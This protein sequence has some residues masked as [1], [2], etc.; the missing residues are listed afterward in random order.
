MA[1]TASSPAEITELLRQWNDGRPG[2]LDQLMPVVIEPLRQLARSHLR[3]EAARHSL[4][5]TALVNEVYLRLVERQQV[6]WQ[7]RSQFFGCTAQLM[8]RI[9]VDHARARRTAKR[10]AITISLDEALG[11]PQSQDLDLIALDEALEDLAR[12]DPRQS[13][14]VVLRFFGGLRIDEVAEV[15]QVGL[16]T[17]SRDWA[18]AR[19][20]LFR[21]LKRS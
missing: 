9:L 11:L 17:V 21:E 1:D 20:W 18:M 16:A 7:N 8:R 4:Q 6:Y 14:V 12:I 15:L 5:P 13:R 2:A 10:S 19:A 3:R